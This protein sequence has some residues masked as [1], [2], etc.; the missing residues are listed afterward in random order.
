MQNKFCIAERNLGSYAKA[1][2]GAAARFRRPLFGVPPFI[3]AYPTP[4]SPPP[5]RGMRRTAIPLSGPFRATPVEDGWRGAQPEKEKQGSGPAL[6]PASTPAA[7]LRPAGR[8]FAPRRPA[9]SASRWSAS[10]VPSQAAARGWM[11]IQNWAEGRT[12]SR[13]RARSNSV[14]CAPL[15]K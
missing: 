7:F 10:C 11:P 15:P 12:T 6:K 13:I 5:G 2:E 1:G 14:G 3:I 9:H 4:Y 8:S